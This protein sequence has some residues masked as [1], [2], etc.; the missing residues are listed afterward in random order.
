MVVN[1]AGFRLWAPADA[2]EGWGVALLFFSSYAPALFFF[3]TGLGIGLRPEHTATTLRDTAFKAGLLVV[4]DQLSYW[5][6]GAWGGLDFFSFIALSMLIVTGLSFARHPARW[7]VG[8]CAAVLALRFVAG[9][10]FKTSWP[11]TGF[12]AAV[13]GVHGQPGISYPV[14]PW[15]C[16]PLAGFLFGLAARQRLT[17][18]SGS[19]RVP[20]AWVVAAVAVL[21][22]TVGALLLASRGASFHRWG[23]VALGF[24]VLSLA[25]IGAAWLMSLALARW[26]PSVAEAL[27]LRGVAAYLVV[28]LHYAALEVLTRL[29]WSGLA[30]SL[31]VPTVIALCGAA[32]IAA[33]SGE[34]W[35]LRLSRLDGAAVP[36]AAGVLGAVCVAAVVLFGGRGHLPVYVASV[37]AQLLVAYG[38]AK[39]IAASVPRDR[40]P[41]VGTAGMGRTP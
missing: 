25:V 15:L 7:A 13:V 20:A 11:E 38:L 24:F 18:A 37:L 2:S 14:S 12:V 32:L 34:R 5:R 27:S 33:K 3:A 17:S 1:H 30:S 6:G 21:L 35:A 28:P 9:P 8:L 41:A 4:A 36:I 29:G 19:W 26:A 39:R 22:G 16:F 31:F 10:M 23:S 40:S